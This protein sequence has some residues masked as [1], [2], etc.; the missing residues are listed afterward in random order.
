MV[1]LKVTLLAQPST[2][3]LAFRNHI[4]SLSASYLLAFYNTYNR[5]NPDT[6]WYN[7]SQLYLAPKFEDKLRPEE[8]VWADS[9]LE[10]KTGY[11][12]AHCRYSSA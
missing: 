1:S 9:N 3:T 6:H 7:Q 11:S 4:S 10:V 2:N 12:C 8:L 5:W